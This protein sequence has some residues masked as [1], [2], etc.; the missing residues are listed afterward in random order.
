MLGYETNRMPQTRRGRLLKA[1]CRRI[2]FRQ[3]RPAQTGE[4]DFG[5]LHGREQELYRRSMLVDRERR[6]FREYEGEN[7]PRS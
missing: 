1:C 3:G 6:I 5:S 4:G 7:M 2:L